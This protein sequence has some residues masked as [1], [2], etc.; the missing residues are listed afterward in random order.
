MVDNPN[1]Q[2]E[3]QIAFL[4]LFMSSE[5]LIVGIMIGHEQPHERCRVKVSLKN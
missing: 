1:E 2:K 3:K 5:T 4:K